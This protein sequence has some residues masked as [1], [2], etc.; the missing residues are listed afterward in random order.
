M[1]MTH[2]E[3]IACT[4][5]SFTCRS[6]VRS[7]SHWLAACIDGQGQVMQRGRLLPCVV[8][9]AAAGRT[10]PP[11]GLRRVIQLLRVVCPLPFAG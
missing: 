8:R 5:A 3:L 6:A 1:R 11:N 9:R 10:L 4:E 7:T 2:V